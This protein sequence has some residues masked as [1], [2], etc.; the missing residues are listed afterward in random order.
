LRFYRL[1]FA[2]DARQDSVQWVR[3]FEH[4]VVGVAIQPGAS[5]VA[6]SVGVLRV[7]DPAGKTIAT[8]ELGR[9]LRVATIRPGAWGPAASAPATEAPAAEAPAASL[10]E[11]LAAAAALPDSRL[12]AGRGDGVEPARD[13]QGCAV[14]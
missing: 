2:L 11:Q 5:L 13:S 8:R 6:D 7:L 10:H 14:T 1:L 4:D 3:T 12:S 9:G